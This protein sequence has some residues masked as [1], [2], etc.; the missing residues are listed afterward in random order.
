MLNYKKLT[1]K[2]NEFLFCV[3]S[4]VKS[5]VFSNPRYYGH[6]DCSRARKA[7]PEEFSGC[8]SHFHSHFLSTTFTLQHHK[9]KLQSAPPATKRLMTSDGV[10]STQLFSVHFF[11]SRLTPEYI[12]RRAYQNSEIIK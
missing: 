4:Q 8:Y 11:L 1:P 10:L 7:F 12:S 9:F 2:P 6:W 3:Y 5:L